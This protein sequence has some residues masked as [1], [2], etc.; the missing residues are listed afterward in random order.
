MHTNTQPHRC[1]RERAKKLER[2]RIKTRNLEAVLSADEEFEFS[3]DNPYVVYG[4]VGKAKGARDHVWLRGHWRKGMTFKQCCTILKQQPDFLMETSGLVKW[5]VRKGHGAVKTIVS[6]PQ[7]VAKEYD[8][9]KSKFE[10]RNHINTKSTSLEIYRAS[11]MKS[12][13]RH[14]YISRTGKPRPPPLPRRRHWRFIRRA[15]DYLRAFSYFDKELYPTPHALEAQASSTGVTLYQLM[16]QTKGIFKTHRCVGEQEFAFTT[17]DDPNDQV[18]DDDDVRC[19]RYLIDDRPVF[20]M[21][22]QV[23]LYLSSLSP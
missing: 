7:S 16:E 6:T 8:W 12:L 1:V 22:S 3:D 20:S 11:V 10:F 19:E 23:D 14:S 13:G 9:G 2:K 17:R 5:W 21:E 4:Y 18:A 15:N